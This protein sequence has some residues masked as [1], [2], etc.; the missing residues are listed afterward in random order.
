[1]L[2]GHVRF[3]ENGIREATELH[4]LQYRTTYFNG[5][6]FSV[7]GNLSERLRLVPVAHYNG[8]GSLEY[9]IGLDRESIWPGKLFDRFS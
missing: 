2:Q 8:N 6:P 7:D 1:M 4:V 9:I 5:T 3:G